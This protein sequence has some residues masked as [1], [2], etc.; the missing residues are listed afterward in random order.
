M[1]FGIAG[2]LS[3]V[4]APHGQQA[5]PGGASPEPAGRQGGRGPGRAGGP[6]PDPVA[7]IRGRAIFTQTCA[8]CHGPDGRGGLQLGTDLSRSLVATANDAGEQLAALLKTGR[9]ERGMPAFSIPADDVA[10]LSAFCRSIAAPAGGAG[11]GRNTIN[12]VVVG[13]P[14]AGQAYFK[15]AGCMQCHS[16]TGD[17]RGIGSRLSVAAIQGRAVMPRGSGGYP[18]GF[19]SMPDPNEK[20]KTVTIT[21]ASG[22]KTTGTLLWITDFNV[23]FV[24]AAGARRTV[25]RNGDVPKVEIT[26]P[27]AWHIEHLKKL[28]DKDM[29]DLT[30][31]LVTLK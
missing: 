8:T 19:N 6:P 22:D 28:T 17:L 5:P 26:D 3:L 9:P 21:P 23:T 29:H 18:R 31:Y 1:V 16:A 27:L 24:D 7:V 14:A 10:D 30:A 12:A 13:D 2:V 4:S 20:P 11:A 15:S 25:A